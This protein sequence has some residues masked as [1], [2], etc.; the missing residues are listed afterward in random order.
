MKNKRIFICYTLFH[1]Y[2]SILKVVNEAHYDENILIITDHVYNF[3]SIKKRI[4][5]RGYFDEVFIVEDK[6]MK[7][8]FDESFKNYGFLYG[9]FKKYVFFKYNVISFFEKYMSILFKQ[10]S[11]PKKSEINL[12]LDK[13]IT[14]FYFMFTYNDIRL[15]E[16]GEGLYSKEKFNILITFLHMLGYPAPDGRNKYI[17]VVEATRPNELKPYVRKK[18]KHLNLN[19]L[20]GLIS[21]KQ[22]NEI[23]SLFLEN[24]FDLKILENTVL[25]ITQPFSEDG[26]ISETEKT[27][28]YNEIIADYSPKYKVVLKPH[29]REQTDYK[30][31][32]KEDILV[33]D[34]NFPLEILDFIIEDKII[35]GITISSSAINNLNC[36]KNRIVLGV[37]MVNVKR[38]TYFK[39][40]G[41]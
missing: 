3:N 32:V 36:L 34:K 23:V 2:V 12:F 21:K 4:E 33:I 37:D 16:D 25:L 27:V 28:M 40:E 19:E 5:E 17:K 9:K 7:N 35:T 8:E 18:A 38:K 20:S 1:I 15:I 31:V 30:S 26:V 41:C 11:I 24:S 14:S 39:G 10:N 22:K 29:P 13:T 6:K